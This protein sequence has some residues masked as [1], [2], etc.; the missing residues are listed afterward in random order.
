MST[1][2]S[3]RRSAESSAHRDHDF[4]DSTTV[5]LGFDSSSPSLSLSLTECTLKERLV[6][7]KTEPSISSLLLR[8]EPSQFGCISRSPRA[9]TSAGSTSGDGPTTFKSRQHRDPNPTRCKMASAKPTIIFVPG[10]PGTLQISTHQQ[11]P[12]L[13]KQAT[14]LLVSHSRVSAQNLRLQISAQTSTPSGERYKRLQT[15]VKL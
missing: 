10:E 14:K 13:K 7:S 12:S 3:G 2:M 9:T 6:R 15:V 1:R 5:S 8:Y 4:H 11:P